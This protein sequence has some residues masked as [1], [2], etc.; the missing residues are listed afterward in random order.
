MLV[1]KERLDKTDAKGVHYWRC[2]CDCG[3]INY[4]ANLGYLSSARV[5]HCGCQ[6]TPLRGEQ[7]IKTILERYNLCFNIEQT[8]SNLKYISYLRCDF[9]ILD[10]NN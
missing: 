9:A 8:S 7:E 3:N 5:A 10:D 4:V 2:E 1:A 6:P